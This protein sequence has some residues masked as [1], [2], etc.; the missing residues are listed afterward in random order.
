MAKKLKNPADQRYQVLAEQA[1][2]ESS[3]RPNFAYFGDLEL[4]K[5]WAF[6]IARSR[7]SEL[8]EE[9]NFATVK[10]DLEKQFPGDVENVHS[11]H[12]AVG[13]VDELAV[14]MLDKKGK[15]TPAGIAALEWQEKLDDYP[16]ADEEDYSEREAEATIDNIMFEGN[17]DRPRAEEVYG[18]LANF[19][20]RTLENRDD[21]GGY[22]S[23]EDIEEALKRLGYI[24]DDD[25]EEWGQPRPASPRPPDDPSQLKLFGK[26]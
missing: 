16:V 23:K 17:I 25:T 2:K 5:S 10:N 20:Q 21:R 15:V 22:P 26:W 11:S 4:G 7:D 13:W 6:V 12:W 1:V 8:L 18:W 3:N 14:R 19:N 9:S 24:K